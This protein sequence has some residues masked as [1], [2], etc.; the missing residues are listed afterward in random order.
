MPAAPGT[1][2]Q[3]LPARPPIRR[4]AALLSRLLALGACGV[5]AVWLVSRAATDR[6]IATQY[7]F[8]VPTWAYLGTSALALAVSWLLSFT[9]RGRPSAAAGRRRRRPGRVPRLA[10]VLGLAA[11]TVFMLLVEWRLHALAMRPPAGDGLRVLYWNAPM[12]PRPVADAVL[13]QEADLVM[14]ANPVWTLPRERVG[15]RMGA[16]AE[17]RTA[18]FL[19]LSR[20]PVLRWGET[21]LGLEGLEQVPSDAWDLV[22]LPEGS[23]DEGRAMFFELDAS[24]IL[25]RPIVVW[26]IDLPSDQRLARWEMLGAAAARIGAWEGP[27]HGEG[28]AS[29]GPARGFPAPDMVVGDFNTPRGSASL[30][31]LTGGMANAYDQGGAG[32]TATFPRER[33]LWHIDQMFV[34]PA[35]RARRYWTLTPDYGRHRIQMADIEAAEGPRRPR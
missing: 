17:V 25:G 3:A 6:T 2:A 9:G 20:Y 15:E 28:A 8:W 34:A 23:I 29:D 33:P 13:A 27:A 26:L 5:L 1:E 4:L 22:E 35:L 10:G 21:S 16:A 24:E 19:V 11:A 18:R 12:R 30:R 31:F 14:I 32:Y 7:L